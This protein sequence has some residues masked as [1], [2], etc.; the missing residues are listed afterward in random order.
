VFIPADKYN[1]VLEWLPVLCV[2]VLIIHN[3]KC[4][5]LLRENEPAKGTYWFP[6]G[7]INKNEQIKEAAL[8]KAM[9]ETNL[10]CDFDKIISV[11]ES[12]FNKTGNMITDVHTV[13][14]CCALYT[15]DI[16]ALRL[17]K[18]HKSYL[19]VNKLSDD[20]HN[21]VNHPLSLIGFTC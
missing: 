11:E 12:F 17:D 2:D 7:R 5:L 20:Y 16:S 6:G 14:I 21:A 1:F 9:E 13:N 19:W 15:E 4:L 18:F 8:R 3:E 10:T